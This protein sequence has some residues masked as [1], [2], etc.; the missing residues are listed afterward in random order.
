[1]DRFLVLS[2]FIWLIANVSASA[3][4]PL[5][6]TP[7]ATQG[8]A[9]TSEQQPAIQPAAAGPTAGQEGQG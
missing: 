8:A 9:K 4:Q 5:P 7:P 6:A 2:L 1:M 3:Q